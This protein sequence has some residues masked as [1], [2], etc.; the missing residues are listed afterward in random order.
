MFLS[1][2]I[3]TCYTAFTQ[4]FQTQGISSIS[5]AG[6]FVLKRTFVC[7]DGMWF[8]PILNQ[9]S[10]LIFL[11]GLHGARGA[12]VVEKTVGFCLFLFGDRFRIMAALV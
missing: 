7:E 9:F 2:P 1:W 8:R 10:L 6:A 5:I 3:F 12:A 11:G 4:R